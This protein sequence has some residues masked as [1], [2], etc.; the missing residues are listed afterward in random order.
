MD[1]TTT[2]AVNFETREFIVDKKSAAYIDSHNRRDYLRLEFENQ[3]F[4]CK[5]FEAYLEDNWMHYP[6][7][8]IDPGVTQVTGLLQTHLI[9]DS[10]NVYQYLIKK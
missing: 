8:S 1:V 9:M 2:I 7:K 6:I 10:L 3:Y 5:V 4:P